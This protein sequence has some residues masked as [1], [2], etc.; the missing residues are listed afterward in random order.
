MV[1]HSRLLQSSKFSK[2]A[3][4]SQKEQLLAQQFFFLVAQG[5]PWKC[6][7]LW[8]ISLG[9]EDI[10]VVGQRVAVGPGVW[11]GMSGT[12]ISRSSWA[13][14]LLP[15][16]EPDIYTTMQVA[17]G[18]QSPPMK[19]KNLVALSSLQQRYLQHTQGLCQKQPRPRSQSKGSIHLWTSSKG[20]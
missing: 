13:R 17:E 10:H 1:V 6:K 11:D 8:G 2:E 16:W 14:G 15:T 18:S 5:P 20:L 12:A 7:L 19:G 9:G 3:P 4:E